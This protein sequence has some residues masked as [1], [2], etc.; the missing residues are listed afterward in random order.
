MGYIA[1]Y[2][3]EMFGADADNLGDSEVKLH[4]VSAHYLGNLVLPNALTVKF[5]P[6]I[7]ECLDQRAVVFNPGELDRKLWSSLLGAER[8]IFLVQ[9]KVNFRSEWIIE[10][11]LR[12][13]YYLCLEENWRVLLSD[14]EIPVDAP[15]Y[16]GVIRPEVR[17]S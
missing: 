16:L 13:S 14:L 5:D 15:S 6:S 12:T 1:S 8:D 2:H 9:N 3:P 11:Q 7:I 4:N 17:L 10:T